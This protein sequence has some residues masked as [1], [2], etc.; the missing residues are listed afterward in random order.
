M[1]GASDYGTASHR[2]QM[3]SRSAHIPKL[4]SSLKQSRLYSH[5]FSK[6]GLFYAKSAFPR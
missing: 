6:G 2:V 3:P 4:S 5:D 1:T